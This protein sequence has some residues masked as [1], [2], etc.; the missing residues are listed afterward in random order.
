MSLVLRRL[1]TRSAGFDAALKGVLH[2]SAQADDAIAA[3]VR[4]IL[5]D[6]RQR[7]DAALLELTA[8]FDDVHE[9]GRASCRE[10]V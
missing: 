2:G 7:G 5:D 3:S 8:R 9:I 6:V 1:D 10:R 4:A